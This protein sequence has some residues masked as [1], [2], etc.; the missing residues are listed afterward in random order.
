MVKKR[1]SLELKVAD[2]ET[3]KLTYGVAQCISGSN[4][5]NGN[6]YTDYNGVTVLGAWHWL[7]ELKWGV[8]T[9]IDLDEGYEV[10]H[11]LHFITNSILF[12]IA[13]PVLLAAY[14]VGRRLSN[15]ILRLRSITDKMASG[16]DLS[17]RI[18]I[19]QKDEIGGLADAFNKMVSSLETNTME[20][21]ASQMKYKRRTQSIKEGIYESE[22]G[23]DGA[24]T[25]TWINQAGA[26]VL[27]YS[28][29]EEVIGVKVDTIYVDL[30]DRKKLVEKLEKNGEWLGFVSHCKK[31]NGEQFYMERTSNMV[32]D[33]NGKPILIFGVFRDITVRKKLAEKL[34]TSEQ[35]YKSLLNSIH[36]GVYQCIPGID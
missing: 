2:P 15:P 16:G 32:R 26:E 13:F 33:N 6:G 5:F 34:M 14:L 27:G 29:P 17:Q 28:A 31:S 19:K 10:S 30:N 18:D 4:G 36:D 1:C 3:G 11:N 23:V 20:L 35:H 8:I 12:A 9:E 24:Y 7:P 21:A 22:P 25:F